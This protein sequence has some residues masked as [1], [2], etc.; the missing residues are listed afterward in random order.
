M[1]TVEIVKSY[2]LVEMSVDISRVFHRKLRTPLFFHSLRLH[3]QICG[4]HTPW[5]FTS[6][7]FTIVSITSTAETAGDVESRKS[8]NAGWH[9]GQ[10]DLNGE[11]TGKN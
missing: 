5:V 1:Q 8:E 2:D 11:R 9:A 10:G 6:T 3:Q 4:L 7:G